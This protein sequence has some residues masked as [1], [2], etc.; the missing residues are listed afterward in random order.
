MPVYPGISIG[1]TIRA[2]LGDAAAQSLFDGRTIEQ[3]RGRQAEIE[4]Q[5]RT[6]AGTDRQLR[7]LDKEKRK[8]SQLIRDKEIAEGFTNCSLI[9]LVEDRQG[10]KV[11]TF[12]PSSDYKRQIRKAAA[13]EFRRNA[14]RN[15]RQVRG[16]EDSKPLKWSQLVVSVQKGST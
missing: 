7:S 5:I 4:H 13:K 3:L 2:T 9:P 12:I 16:Q 10:R 11:C 6:S 14:G 8:I 1:T 15:P